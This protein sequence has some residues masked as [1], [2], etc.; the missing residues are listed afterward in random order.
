[1]SRIAWFDCPAGI[2]GDMA[3]AAL[4]HAGADPARIRAAVDAV[5][6]RPTGLAVS[7]A[8]DS[9]VA[10]LRLELDLPHEHVHRTMADIAAM[11]EGAR[12]AVPDGRALDNALK[13]FGKLAAAEG[14]VHGCTPGAVSF[15]EVGALDSIVDIVGVAVALDDLGVDIVTASPLPMT[16]GTVETA[17]GIL[18][19]PAPATLEVLR[20]WEVYGV[21]ARGEFVTPTGAAICA[22]LAGK[23]GPMPR[24]TITAAGLGFGRKKWPD[25]RPNCVRVVI[26]EASDIGAESR[27]REISANIDDSTPEQISWLAERLLAVGALDAWV[28]PIHMKKG[29]PAWTV[30]ALSTQQDSDRLAEVFFAESSTIGVRITDLDR[31]TLDREIETVETAFGPVRVKTARLHGR[32]VNVQPEADDLRAAAG[33]TGIPLKEIRKKIESQLR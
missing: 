5:C 25:G 20:G 10:G 1:M 21:D 18:P 32:V 2:A 23:A 24:M 33:R 15:H 17:H 9:P 16:Q 13:I 27:V 6:G 11:I 19:V 7:T 8:G 28:T 3:L 4:V 12:G 22:A 26:G 31:I 14:V 29:R 30:S